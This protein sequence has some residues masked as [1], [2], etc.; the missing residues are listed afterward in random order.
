VPAGTVRVT[1]WLQAGE[2]TSGVAPPANPGGPP[3]TD[4]ISTAALVNSW[5]GPIWDGYV[6]LTGSQPAQVAAADGGPA[7]LP[8]P[9]VE[10]AGSVNLQ[11]FFYAIEWWVFGLFAL[12]LW[13]RLVLDEAASQAPDRTG[14]VRP[15]RGADAGIAGLPG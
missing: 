8:R 1:G 3:L 15:R 13:V 6:V 7:A 5:G 10:G 12:G 11:S 14:R 4:A 2:A 9:V